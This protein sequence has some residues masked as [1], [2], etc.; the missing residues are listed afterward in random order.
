MRSER[1]LQNAGWECDTRR[2]NARNG[3]ICRVLG[4]YLGKRRNNPKYAMD[5]S[6]TATIEREG[7]LSKRV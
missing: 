2:R 1:I 4:R 5:G 3:K 6:G 7:K